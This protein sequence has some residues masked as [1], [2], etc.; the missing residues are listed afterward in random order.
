MNNSF[1]SIIPQRLTLLVLVFFLLSTVYTAIGTQEIAPP[2]EA[3][4]KIIAEVAVLKTAG[5]NDE[6]LRLLKKGREQFPQSLHLRRETF[7]LLLS[8]KRYEE[9][10]AFID[11]TYPDT[12]DRFKKDVLNS[13]RNILFNMLMQTLENGDFDKGYSYLK[14][15]ADS[16]HK[17]PYQF[18]YQK[19]YKPLQE[20]EGFE[21]I[22][23]KIEDNAGIDRPPLDFTSALLDGGTF[24]LSEQKG[25]VVLV[26]FWNTGC[27]PCIKEFPNLRKLYKMYQGKGLEIISISLDES[28]EKLDRFLEKEPLP[29]KHIFSGKGWGD[30]IARMYEVHSNPY[31]FLVDRKGI[32]RYFDVRGEALTKAVTHLIK[33]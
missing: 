15:L 28:R 21:E 22:V 31:L 27:G 17:N 7:L 5:K 13:K 2:S 6:A 4:Q 8:T 25:K 16:G 33:E 32:M 20:M 3:E 19:Q 9:C 23:E 10:I 11:E 29:W 14:D 26:D 1:Y 24:T 12:P 18:L 30:E